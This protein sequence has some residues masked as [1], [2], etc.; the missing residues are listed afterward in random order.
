M[1]KRSLFSHVNWDHDS[2][3]DL[4]IK[5]VLALG[6]LVAASTQTIRMLVHLSDYRPGATKVYRLQFRRSIQAVVTAGTVLSYEVICCSEFNE[7][8][9]LDLTYSVVM[10]KQANEINVLNLG[11]GINVEGFKK[12][13]KP[14]GI[15]V[16][17]H[18]APAEPG[19]YNV[20][21]APR[22]KQDG[23][24][25]LP[26]YSDVFMVLNCDE[27]SQ[28]IQSTSSF[29]P[30]LLGC[31]RAFRCSSQTVLIKEEYGSTLGSHIYDS[32]VVLV[33]YI[34][35]HLLSLFDMTKCDEHFGKRVI[36]ELGAGCGMVG[37]YLA[38]LLSFTT[39]TS[40][41]ID[42]DKSGLRVNSSSKQLM[43]QSVDAPTEQPES[44]I[45]ITD[46]CQ[47]R[48]LIEHNISSNA[49]LNTPA[50]QIQYADLDWADSS[51]FEKLH[52]VLNGSPVDLV[53]AG[54]VFYDRQVAAL[55]FNAVN[56]L[57]IHNEQLKVL[58][59]Q[60]LRLNQD[61]VAAALIS[62]EEIRAQCGFVCVE[63]VHQEAD[64]IL[65]LLRS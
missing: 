63:K 34:E 19:F 56:K 6:E 51:H 18:H 52:D 14:G 21:V 7:P 40:A 1:P 26:V 13:R 53:V 8:V 48:G 44:T 4:M 27:Y 38:A 10:C 28:Y 57:R 20:A 62:E 60:K 24:I 59:A 50:T 42:D 25:L 55:F 49:H 45:I 12:V 22:E 35:S 15:T 2:N 36:L 46:R 43:E 64:V 9:G 33:R 32:S 29:V 31:Y 17:K 58:V 37:L 54:D 16:I 39:T 3:D 65:W 47:Q 11:S 5:A 30:R 61:N 41:T 23:H